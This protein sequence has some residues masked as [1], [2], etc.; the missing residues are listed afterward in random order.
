MFEGVQR[1]LGP[2]GEH[3]GAI[4]PNAPSR[5]RK[6]IGNPLKK[7]IKFC[8]QV[9]IENVEKLGYYADIGRKVL[10]I[11]SM[12]MLIV[13]AVVYLRNYYTGGDQEKVFLIYSPRLHFPTI[14][15]I[16]HLT[17]IYFGETVATINVFWT[18]WRRVK[19]VD[20]KNL[21]CV[22]V[23]YKMG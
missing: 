15:P 3:L 20:V 19:P 13:D 8:I 10:T 7:E 1:D 9:V 14:Y 23:I 2:P 6:E 11:L 18:L 22:A 17:K 5:E 16:Y 4:A 12:V 21:F